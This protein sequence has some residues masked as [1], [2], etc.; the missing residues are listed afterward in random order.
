MDFFLIMERG[1]PVTPINGAPGDVIDQ[2]RLGDVVWHWCGKPNKI[3]TYRMDYGWETISWYGLQ[4]FTTYIHLFGVWFLMTRKGCLK[5]PSLGP[6]DPY[7]K[8]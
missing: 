5:L 8:L 4:P 7:I 3:A 2:D 6:H 1:W